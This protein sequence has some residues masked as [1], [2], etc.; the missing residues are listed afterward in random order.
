MS[1][2]WDP[3]DYHP[4]GS[5][6]H[7]ILQARK[8]EWV[9]MIL[10][11]IF[12]TQ[13]L[14][15]HVLCLQHW[16]AGSLPLVPRGKA[17]KTAGKCYSPRAPN[18]RW[19]KRHLDSLKALGGPPTRSREKLPTAAGLEAKSVLKLLQGLISTLNLRET[20]DVTIHGPETNG[21]LSHGWSL[22]LGW[23]KHGRS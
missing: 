14:S 12:P 9:A 11:G 17:H 2:L 15:P 23:Y 13:G 21:V 22:P 5:S 16:Q 19:W 10:Q 7:G 3:M 8:L 1:T 20:Q 6:V 4:P 18:R